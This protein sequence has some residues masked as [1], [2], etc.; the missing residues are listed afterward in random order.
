MWIEADVN[1][2]AC[3]YA[4]DSQRYCYPRERKKMYA[5]SKE[6]HVRVRQYPQDINVLHAIRRSPRLDET[7]RSPILLLDRKGASRKRGTGIRGVRKA[8][9]FHDMVSCN[10]RKHKVIKYN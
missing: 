9:C 6:R 10:T 5:E 2:T 1:G 7:A 4:G 3:K 8:G